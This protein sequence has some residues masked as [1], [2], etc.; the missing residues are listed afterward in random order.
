MIPTFL[1]NLLKTEPPWLHFCVTDVSSITNI[2]FKLHREC[3][4]RFITLRL[5]GNKMRNISALFNEFGA[6]LQFPYY[7]GENGNAFDEC[8]N[9]LDW[10]IA[11][12]YVLIIHDA[13]QLLVESTSRDEQTQSI[14][15][16][17]ASAGEEW[18]RPVEGGARARPSRPFHVVFQTDSDKA[19]MFRDRLK[20]L[21]VNFSELSL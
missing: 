15:A 18:S 7:F 20:K 10:L 4:K 1:E 11:P 6:A 9:D 2:A 19:E 5:R 17:L 3:R 8:I 13:D 21:G 14:M 16:M 12:G